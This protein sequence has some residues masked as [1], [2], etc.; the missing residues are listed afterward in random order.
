MQFILGFTE[1]LI[2]EPSVLVENSFRITSLLVSGII[3]FHLSFHQLYKPYVQALVVFAMDFA[4]G[5]A[6]MLLL[7]PWLGALEFKDVLLGNIVLI[8]ALIIGTPIGVNLRQKSKM[9]QIA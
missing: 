4:T 9:S 8:L 5:L 2:F 1:G 6:L 3:F 7:Y